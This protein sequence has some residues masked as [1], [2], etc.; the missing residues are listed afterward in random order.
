[1][2]FPKELLQIAKVFEQNNLQCFCVGGA[3]RDLLLK[4]LVTD[5][6]IA[7]DA[8]P[9]EIRDLFKRTIPTGIK[10]G[11]VTI[12]FGEHKFETTTFRIDGDYSDKRKPDSVVF[13]P[14]IE[15][16]LKR[17]DFTIN[18]IA[19]DLSKHKL[20]DPNHGQE[21]LKKK[22][23]RAIGDPY[24]R[25]EEDA[26]RL[27]RACRFAAQ[28]DFTLEQKTFEAIT[29]LSSNIKNV[30]QERI[31]DEFVKILKSDNPVSGFEYMKD[32]GL[33][34]H[35]LPE[36]DECRG[37]NQ[38]SLHCFD[39]YYHSLY[40]CE[41][42]PKDN[43]ILRLASLLHDIGK[44]KTLALNEDGEP[45]F[46]N[47]EK[48]SCEQSIEIL[49]RLR[50]STVEIKSVSHL[51]L[52]HMFNYTSEWSDSAVRRFLNRV[53]A[54][55]VDDIIALRQADQAGACRKKYI[56]GTLIEFQDRIDKVIEEK[57]AFTIADL[58]VNGKDIMILLDLKP[59]PIVGIIL[60]YLLEAVLD[61]PE[62]NTKKRLL[63]I[64]GRF[65]N[66]RLMIK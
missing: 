66:D 8:R 32:S 65:Y 34:A 48:K 49:K 33:L 3:V 59:G 2:T 26:L 25:F 11:T 5:F 35:V 60:G 20:F 46:Y 58:A 63:E 24:S 51:I 10:H 56:N 12:L 62:Q 42:A 31:R 44:A 38:R 6:D 13:T 52:H 21:D 41:A 47:H 14:S 36:L 37:I 27:L 22:T 39:V 40:T 28:L 17:R 64:A 57:T 50:F 53:G 15:E 54:D 23:I 7:T 18:A 55:S 16:D 29:G 45:T 43:L 61:D 1:M 4:R 19:Y 9:E 30:S